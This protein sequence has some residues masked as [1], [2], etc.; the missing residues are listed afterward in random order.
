MTYVHV[1]HDCHIGDDVIIAN[2]TQLAGHVTD[3]RP[4]DRQ[5]ARR[6]FTS[7]CASARYAF[8]GGGSPREPGR[9]ALR[10]GRGQSGRAVRSQF[11]RAP[12]RRL[13]ARDHRRRSSAPTG[14]SSIPTSTCAPGARA[15]PQRA[16]AAARGG[17]LPRASSKIVRAGRAGVSSRPVRVGVIGV[18]ALGHHHARQLRRLPGAELVGY[19]RHRSRPRRRGRRRARDQRLRRPR[20]A[21][22]SRRSRVR[23]GADTGTRGRRLRSARSG[24]SPALIEKPLADTLERR[25][26][27]WSPRRRAAGVRAP[28][29]PR[30]ALQPRGPR[31]ASPISTSRASSRVERLAPFQPRGTDVAVVLDLMI[32]DLDLVLDLDRRRRGGRPG[33]RACRCFT[34]HLDI[35]NARVEF[36]NGAVAMAT[37]SRVSAGADAT[38]GMLPAHRI[39]LARSRGRRRGVHA[40]RRAEWVPGTGTAARRGGRA[41][42]LSA[43]EADALR[44]SLPAS[45]TRSAASATPS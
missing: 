43:P 28:G 33:V 13:S 4:R 2:S 17:V 38:L 34:P 24:A 8:V 6:R 21:A 44:W 1:A 20:R 30:R 42:S 7:S 27:S 41:V 22:R 5:R 25:R 39:F 15:G 16:A 29:G 10:Q 18:G 19:L 11:D 31:R 23:R 36:A 9:A 45:S 14:C 12:A 3:R 37:A 32:H 40:A 26:R 35:A